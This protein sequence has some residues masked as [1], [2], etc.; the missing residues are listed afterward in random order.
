MENETPVKNCSLEVGQRVVVDKE[1][2]NRSEATIMCFT[3]QKMFATVRADNGYEWQ[4]MSYRLSPL[5]L[6]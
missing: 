5:E 2:S 3:P 4:I 1:K 6:K